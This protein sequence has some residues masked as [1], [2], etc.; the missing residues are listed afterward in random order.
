MK[1]RASPKSPTAYRNA[2]DCGPGNGPQ[3][4]LNSFSTLE[5]TDGKFR[6][7]IHTS[8]DVDMPI[9]AYELIR[10]KVESMTP[11]KRFS[12]KVHGTPP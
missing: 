3:G 10:N 7:L 1:E 9:H 8:S 4:I 11:L 2:E 6:K 5:K 12:D